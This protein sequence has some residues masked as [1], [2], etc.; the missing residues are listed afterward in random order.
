VEAIVAQ[1]NT[2]IEKYVVDMEVAQARINEDQ[3]TIQFKDNQLHEAQN[4][5]NALQEGWNNQKRMLGEKDEIIH[6]LRNEVE[7]LNK[8]L[9][10]EAEPVSS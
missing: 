7:K 10:G 5:M 2:L 3:A 1:K 8:E 6:N 9:T 4:Q